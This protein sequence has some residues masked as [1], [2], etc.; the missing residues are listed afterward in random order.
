VADAGTLLQSFVDNLLGADD[1]ATTLA[2][3]SSN[4]YF[5]LGVHD[6]I[7]QRVG[8]EPRED[9]GVNGANTRAGEEG[10]D[11]L[12]NHGQVERDS[13]T[14]AH[15]HL[16]QCVGELRNLAEKLSVG[17]DAAIAS[18]VCLVDNGRLVWVLESVTVNAVVAGIQSTFKE[19]RIIAALKATSVY[20]LEV[21]FPR[22][23]FARETSP[24]LVGLCDGLLVQLLV[25]FKAVDVRF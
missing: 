1:F 16:L 19:P 4:N 25:L 5:A 18:I 10:D 14:F 23:Q 7:A 24:E 8:R 13:V 22:E 9:N 20:G 3:V 12:G 6:A 11:R 15:T 21:A 2:L 17:D